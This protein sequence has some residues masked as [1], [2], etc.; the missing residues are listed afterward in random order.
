[1]K[2]VPILPT[3]LVAAAVA[4]MIWLGLWQVRRAEWKE[5]MLATYT[6]AVGKDPVPG[7]PA[8]DAIDSVAF[9]RAHVACTVTSAPIQ[10]GGRNQ[11]SETGFRNFVGCALADG[12]T[13]MADI[14]WS[15]ISAKPVPPSNGTALA[16]IGRLVPDPE[17]AARVIKGA[18]HPLP[19]LVVMESPVPGYQPSLPPEIGDIPN[20]HRSYAVQWFLF[21]S[22]AVI[23]YIIAL[24][25]RWRQR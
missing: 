2:P 19:W 15:G 13:M 14:G 3:I 23:I 22:V 20:N 11:R 17:L 4:T 1:M 7:I 21:A 12:R 9:R 10:Q 24:R 16:S 8:D 25:R 6:A 18:G 5:G